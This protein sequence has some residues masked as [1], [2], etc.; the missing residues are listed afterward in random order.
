MTKRETLASYKKRF[1]DAMKE[2]RY[3][4][5]FQLW[6]KIQEDHH[7]YQGQEDWCDHNSRKLF[8]AFYN[9]SDWSW[10]KQVCEKSIKPGS[11]EGR[12]KRLEDLSGIEYE[13]IKLPVI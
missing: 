10:A 9:K 4:E 12:I 13:K 6:M 2:G 8:Q 5:A 11:K 1:E 7:L 3:L